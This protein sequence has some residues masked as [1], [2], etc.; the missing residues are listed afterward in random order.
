MG[1]AIYSWSYVVGMDDA[2]KESRPH[3]D[4]AAKETTMKRTL[5][6]T[7]ASIVMST[8]LTTSLPPTVYAGEFSSVIW[9]TDRERVE[10]LLTEHGVQA[11]E[12]RARAAALTDEE[13]TRLA[14]EIDALPAGRGGEDVAN[15][16]Y[17]M[18]VLSLMVV[19]LVVF[20]IVKAIEAAKS[21]GSPAIDASRSVGG[22]A[23]NSAPY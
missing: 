10:L 12:A 2:E 16:L 3:K 14:A 8:A 21:T 13:A 20:L 1:N 9:L 15:S 19:A 18:A 11:A 17:G 23:P 5:R 4:H 6:H 7:I 22:P